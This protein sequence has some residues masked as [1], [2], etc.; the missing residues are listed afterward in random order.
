MT[1]TAAKARW[2]A[3]PS[4]TRGILWMLISAFA[5]TAMLGTVKPAS[6]NLHP[7]EV[8][9]FRH[10]FTLL[11][12]LPWMLRLGV[13]NLRT[14]RFPLIA[15]RG[16]LGFISTVLWFYAVP[17]LALADATAIN[18]TAPLWATVFAALILHEPI[19]LR[20]WTATAIGFAGVLVVLRP[21]FQ[22]FSVWALVMLVGAACWGSQ[23]IVLKTLSRTEPTNVIVCYHAILLTPVALILSLFVWR[24]P[25]LVDI[26]WL[27]ALGSLGTVGHL[28]L[29]RSFAAAEASV[30]LPF[31][32]S[33]MPIA[34]AIGYIAFDEH[35]DLWTWAG[36]A[37]I[38][39]AATYI[40]R[41][42]AQIARAKTATRE[43]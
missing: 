40:A 28:C 9:F 32:F 31:D 41:R 20:R 25:G 24:T 30:V 16:L 35:P 4:T 21:G 19:R 34:A 33:K 42:E 11:V 5:F 7:F 13:G 12:M 15:L 3:L 22:D 1:L 26:L 27:V 29:A 23:H 14:K 10:F 36:A 43:N 38:V 8:T 39:A 18:F 17:N 6:K 2:T 37:L